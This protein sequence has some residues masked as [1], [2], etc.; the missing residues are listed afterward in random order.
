M[1]EKRKVLIVDD[2]EVMRKEVATLLKDKYETYEA[3]DGLQALEQVRK[4]VPDMIILDLEMPVMGGF[5]FLDKVDEILDPIP[6]VLI[7][8]TISTKRRETREK[9]A[10]FYMDKP[11]DKERLLTVVEHLLK[12]ESTRPN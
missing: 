1:T 9:G 12:S 11:F 6:P 10:Q 8:T 5:E 3:E 2:A 4:V 7:L